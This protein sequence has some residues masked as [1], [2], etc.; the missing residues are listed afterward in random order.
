MK[1]E[2]MHVV[3]H[4]HWD[5]EW[6][7]SFSKHRY[8]LVQLI[9]DVL[10]YLENG[11]FPYYQMDG[12]FI[13]IED[14]LE[15]RPQNKK[16]IEKLVQEGRLLIGP[17]YVL[18]DE[19]L[20]GG[21][22]NIRN[23][24]YGMDE[25]KKLGKVSMIGHMPDSF[26][27]ISQMPQIL[28]GFGIDNAVFG[29]GITPILFGWDTLP[30][31]KESASEVK[32]KA[33]DGSTIIGVQMTCWYDNA[34]ELPVD[35]KTLQQKLEKLT[36]VMSK[37]QATPYYLGMNGCDHQPLQK[38]LPKA[39]EMAN[40]LGYPL[41]ISNLERYVDSVRPYA[42]TFYEVVGEL[43]SQKTDGY[44]ALR[45]TASARIYI[46][47]LNYKAEYALCS[48]LE[49]LYTMNMLAGGEYD[50]DILDY[51]WK[52]LLKNYPH[53][54]ICCCSVDQVLR[55]ME[56]RFNAVI[57]TC[58]S[59]IN[60]ISTHFVSNE[61]VF[62]SSENIVVY[63]FSP[64]SM[65]EW[66][67]V[68]LLFSADD[69][70][71]EFSIRE[72]NGTEVPFEEI[73]R[74]VKK[75]YELPDDSFRIIHEK[76]V[77]K[78]RIFPN[79]EGFGYKVLHISNDKPISKP[80]IFY[81]DGRIET[82]SIILTIN[83]NGSFDLFD[84]RNQKTYQNQNIYEYVGDIGNEYETKC[85]GNTITSA[86]SK[87]EIVITVND[88][89]AEVK[90]QN[91]MRIPKMFN[92]EANAFEGTDSLKIETIL[93]VYNNSPIVQIRTKFIN[94][95][96]NY[97]L[98]ALFQY[99]CQHE[100]CTA[101]SPFD[102]IQRNIKPEK[103]WKNPNNSDRMNAFIEYADA[104]GGVA[105]SGKGIHE[106]EIYKD[107]KTVGVTLLR[108]VGEMGDWF[109]FSTPEAQCKGVMDVS[110]A[111]I[112]L[113]KED[114]IDNICRLYSFYK[115]SLFAQSC[116][117]LKGELKEHYFFK[118]VRKGIINCSAIKRAKDGNGTII[119]LYNPSKYDGEVDFEMV[120]L[121]QIFY[122]NLDESIER[123]IYG[124]SISVKAKKIITLKIV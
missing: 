58:E 97:R 96:E 11:E 67:E 74:E 64:F 14:Y 114:E 7:M 123:E 110:Y 53:D 60:D 93:T 78:I 113:L 37:V 25:S 33:P 118:F 31:Y 62:N 86:N 39:I 3:P 68:D 42:D 72:E 15:I 29:R 18:Q 121:K 52:T 65:D 34:R 109:Y 59:A 55:D 84:K 19:Y 2:K 90:I 22:C 83:E 56:G 94:N 81:K 112:P 13:P 79:V 95:C 8:R 46:K 85:F 51:S 28:Q 17:W 107:Q 23:L 115:P 35:K 75:L 76:C 45:N 80:S 100:Y 104:H 63:N 117:T 73:S 26:G 40:E 21:E 124:N 116:A 98:R 54:S 48:L 9:D 92:K 69:V 41:E 61:S 89:T 119:R 49:P 38:N 91:E 103:E 20:I 16:R 106:Y 120:G 77:V 82:E 70:N 10:E 66:V 71:R 1:M 108:A 4:S 12:Q 24:A 57:D 87:A 6:Y 102:M 105:I 32:W 27:N 5:R 30:E 99:E 122:C 111:F 101:D 44:G 47:Q 50:Q 36:T 43:N 88:Y